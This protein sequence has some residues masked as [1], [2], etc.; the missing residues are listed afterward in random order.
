MGNYSNPECVKKYI[1]HW[2]PYL[3][4]LISQFTASVSRQLDQASKIFEIGSGTGLLIKQLIKHFGDEQ[5][6]CIQALEP[7]TE[8]SK[9]IPTFQ[10]VEVI[11]SSIEDYITT[12]KYG[13]ERETCDLV[14]VAFVLQE[15]STEQ[16]V[17]VFKAAEEL[18]KLHGHLAMAF[19]SEPLPDFA[20]SAVEESV[21]EPESSSSAVEESATESKSHS[22]DDTA[23][24]LRK[25][26]ELAGDR[27]DVVFA[28]QS[29]S[30]V[31]MDGEDY[32]EYY[33]KEDC[34]I[35]NTQSNASILDDQRIV[36]D[37]TTLILQL[38]TKVKDCTSEFDEMLRAG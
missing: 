5:S 14:L 31:L 22:I 12:T 1:D 15:L 36:L 4:N 9:H 28:S 18:L 8:M 6:V 33:A 2:T 26:I 32:Q 11:E 34:N 3:D 17:A 19:W 25:T 10:N 21:I 38:K 24:S 23:L 37:Y 7:C 35:E 27:W 13:D 16:M 30:R 20:P 29:Y